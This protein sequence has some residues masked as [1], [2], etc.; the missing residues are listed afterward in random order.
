MTS[1][2]YY[3]SLY[4]VSLKA[5]V[6]LTRI[7]TFESFDYFPLIITMNNNYFVALL[8]KSKSFDRLDLT[9]TKGAFYIFHLTQ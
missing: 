9:S 7:A 8:R 6:I 5:G 3:S 4:K 2:I 1:S